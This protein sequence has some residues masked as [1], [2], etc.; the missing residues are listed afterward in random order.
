MTE[1]PFAKKNSSLTIRSEEAME[2]HTHR[3]C[4]VSLSWKSEQLAAAEAQ[5]PRTLAYL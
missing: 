5:N 3:H 4:T 2:N 1:I